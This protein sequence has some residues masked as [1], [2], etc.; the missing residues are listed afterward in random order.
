MTAFYKSP[1]NNNLENNI[2]E[3]T[4]HFSMHL[5]IITSSHP[6]EYHHMHLNIITSI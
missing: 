6:F 5:N 3:I 4:L 1:N 2:T